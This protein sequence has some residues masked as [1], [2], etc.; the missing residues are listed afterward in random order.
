[1]SLLSWNSR[2]SGRPSMMEELKKKI[3]DVRPIFM[4]VMETMCYVNKGVNLIRRLGDF[5]SFVVLIQG[6]SGGLWIFWERSVVVKVIMSKSWF[7]HCKLSVKVNGVSESFFL[8]CVYGNS[9]SFIR[10][11]QWPVLA[12]FQ[13]ANDESWL[14]MGDFNEIT[15]QEE[16]CGGRQFNY[17]KV[18]PFL[19]MI[20]DC[21]LLDLGFVGSIYTWTNR[22]NGHNKIWERIDRMMANEVWRSRFTDCRV[23]HELA[24]SSD[25]KF[26]ILKLIQDRVNVRRPFR[27]EIMWAQHGGCQEQ[28]QDAWFSV[29]LFM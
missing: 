12:M 29:F 25:H 15:C 13:P 7:I 17:S 23:L 18:R 2:G 11:L 27:F 19:E 9:K 28:I 4:L 26:L 10:R 16:K 6:L 22:Q 3:K 20:D 21:E 24:I 8:S 1:M 5:E 14:L